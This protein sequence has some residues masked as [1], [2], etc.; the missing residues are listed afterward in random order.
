MKI[1]DGY[2]IEVSIPSICEP[3][4]TSHVVKS[5]ET[6][7]FENEIHDYTAEVRSSNEL[8]GDLQGSERKVNTSSKETWAMTGTRKLEAD[9]LSL[10]PNKA[11]LNTRR[12]ITMNEKKWITIQA[13]VSRGRPLAVSMSRLVTTMLRHFDQEERQTDGSRYWDSIKSVLVRRFAQQ[14]ARDFD[15]EACLQ[16]IF[17]GSTKRRIVFC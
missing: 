6:D 11:S 14:G 12:I 13:N 8:L 16:M 2:A 1:H 10:T 7:S 15:D 9:S 17:E 5:R 4:D 3:E